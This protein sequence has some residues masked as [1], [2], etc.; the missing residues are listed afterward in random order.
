MSFFVLLGVVIPW[1]T[2]NEPALSMTPWRL[3]IGTTLLFLFRRI[4]VAVLLKKAMTNI[5]TYREAFFLDILDRL[6][7]VQS[8]QHFLSRHK[9]IPGGLGKLDYFHRVH[10]LKPSRPRSCP[11]SALLWCARRS[12]MALLSPFGCLA[13]SS[14]TSEPGGPP[15]LLAQTRNE[16]LRG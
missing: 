15:A 13:D 2:Y 10:L 12:Y 9:W 3:I 1:D 16:F 8:S 14:R 5:K 7:L 6:A 11:P 4:P